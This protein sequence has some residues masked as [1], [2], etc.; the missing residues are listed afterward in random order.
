M[1]W[2]QEMDLEF[3][4]LAMEMCD[5]TLATLV[6]RAPTDAQIRNLLLMS[7]GSPT[8]TC[9]TVMKQ[10][11][12]GVEYLHSQNVVHNDLKPDNI[13]LKGNLPNWCSAVWQ[14]FRCSQLFFVAV[15]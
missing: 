6:Q 15:W 5:S 11:C 14:C 12:K 2:V 3:M 8:A 10:I 1:I 7:Q 9:R 4:Y 13:F